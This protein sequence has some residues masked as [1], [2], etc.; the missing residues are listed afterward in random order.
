M[1]NQLLILTG[2]YAAHNG[3]MRLMYIGFIISEVFFHNVFLVRT[4]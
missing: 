2:E 3:E 4:K 1:L